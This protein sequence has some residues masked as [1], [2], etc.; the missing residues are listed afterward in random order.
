MKKRNIVIHFLVI[1]M[2]IATITACTAMRMQ[3][4]SDIYGSKVTGN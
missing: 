3:D 1:L 2:M 4:V